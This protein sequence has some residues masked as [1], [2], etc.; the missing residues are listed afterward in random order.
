[1]ALVVEAGRGFGDFHL[2]ACVHQLHVGDV[3]A[4]IHHAVGELDFLHLEFAQVK[5]LALGRPVLA[6]GDG[7]HYLARR[8]A[9][10][11]VQGV[12]VL[13]S[14]D[15]KHRTGQA[16][17]FVH[18]L[19]NALAFCHRG[20][21]LAG[22]AD[23]DDSFL[24]HVGLGDFDHRHAAFLAGMIL[25]HIKVNRGAVQYIAIGGLYFNQG[26]SRAVFQLFRRYQ[27][28]LGIGVER[29]NGGRRRVS[30]GHFHLAAIGT[31]N[32]EPGP[33]I[34]DG[35]AGFRVHLDHLDE[36]L[37]IGVVD[38]VA[39]GLAVLGDIH[40]KIVH[41][42]AAFPALGLADDISA[43]GQLLRLCKAVL[44]ADENIAL[45]FLGIF[46]A[47][48]RLE[49]NLE[50]RTGFRGFDLGFPVI[51][52]LDD[53]N[54]SLDDLLRHIVGGIVQLN[55]IQLRFRAY[56]VNGG[57]QQVAL[58]GTDFTDCPVRI[59]DVITGS[60][61]AVLVRG[62]AVNEGISL[63]QPV[64]SAGQGTIALGR[65]RFHIAL[66]NGNAELLQHVVHTLV[67]HFIPLDGGCLGIRHH[68][69]DG[70]IHLL[71]YIACADEYV[72]KARHTVSIRHS[73]LV[74][75]LPGEGCAVQVEGHALHQP[76]LAGFRHF[77]AAAL[78]DVVEIH[79]SG[80]AAD[81]GHAL[82]F[83]GFVLINRLLGYGINAGI[84]VGDVDLA[85]LIGGLGGAVLLAGDGEIDPS[86]LSILGSLNQLHI[87][88]FHFQVQIAYH[89]VGNGFPVGGKVL[90]A[91]ASNSVRPN[92]N[93]AALGSHFF[94]LNGHRAFD[95]LGGSDGELVAIHREIQAGGAAGEGVISQH[96]VF[97]RES[98]GI[99]L[100]IPFQL[101]GT[102]VCG[103]AE[104]A[105]QHGVA[106]D[107]AL[108]GGIL[109]ENLAV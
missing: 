72:F 66:G 35:D 26:I 48:C 53:G 55:L 80:L 65:T 36:A 46:I 107:R 79:G 101:I 5:G 30:E 85:R 71:Q 41:Q 34:G 59:A 2:L 94:R 44:I 77:Q 98:E 43:V 27:I 17:H 97:I 3:L 109:A 8:I 37:K 29:I 96:V 102:G 63:I 45:G 108:N 32:L 84:E 103:A 15:L 83:L 18:R 105:G 75:R 50:L 57:I 47:A 19:V 38:K 12:D 7:V 1:M 56:F 33:R 92:H 70:G 73:I 14:G 21:H 20:E 67:G 62:E 69:T 51:G 87:T 39:V 10:G 106:L 6:G 89:L 95:G 99:L 104:K 31:V 90:F 42:L 61:L 82:G 93:T 49:I 91:A 4:G 81:D 60:E 16:L 11:A 78:E 13:Q 24:G 64:H 28:A 100:A 88:G 25:G 23:F 54:V 76:V 40:F 58:A 86:Y 22:L 68:I 9:Q 74:H 52:M